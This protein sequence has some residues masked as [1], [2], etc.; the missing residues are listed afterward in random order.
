[1]RRKVIKQIKN[2]T[3]GLVDGG[4]SIRQNQ[5]IYQG[6]TK[7]ITWA[8]YQNLAFTLKDEPYPDIYEQCRSNGDYN[9]M[10]LDGALLQMK[11]MFKHD[12]ITEHVL[13][14]MPNPSMENF[15]DNPETFEET[16]FGSKLFSDII[17]E[18]VISFPIR[19]DFTEDVHTELD[20]PKSHVTLGNLSDCRIPVSKP[21]SPYKFICFILRNFY[22]QKLGEVSTDLCCQ[23]RIPE[24]ITDEEKKLVHFSVV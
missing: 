4:L 11:Y 21:L 5:P 3:L 24:T 16:H 10:M 17:D 9:I 20:H 2:I 23:I 6:N 19:F 8:N 1:M 12:K 13:H 14:Y 18:K 15:Q 7:T 22:F